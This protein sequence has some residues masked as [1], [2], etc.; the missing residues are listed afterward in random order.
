MLFWVAAWFCIV[1]C[2]TTLNKTLFTT[3]KCPYP[4]SITLVGFD[5]RISSIDSYV[6][7]LFVHQ[8]DEESYTFL[9]QRSFSS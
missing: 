5:D 9:L 1:I 4:V 6:V 3:L 7:L 8:C 2:V